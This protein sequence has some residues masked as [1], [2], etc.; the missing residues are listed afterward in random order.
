MCQQTHLPVWSVLSG[1]VPYQNQSEFT[2]VTQ[3]QRV[4]KLL[5]NLLKTSGYCHLKYGWGTGNSVTQS[6]LQ[7]FRTEPWFGKLSSTGTPAQLLSAAS[8]DDRIN[9]GW[10]GKQRIECPMYQNNNATGQCQQIVDCNCTHLYPI[11]WICPFGDEIKLK[12]G[13]TH[14]S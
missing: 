11:A 6:K 8:Y 4:W 5:V 9:D 2:S 14:I 12:Q 10:E 1:L 3:D 13:L 7:W